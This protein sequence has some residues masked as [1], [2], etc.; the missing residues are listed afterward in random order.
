MSD[1]AGRARVDKRPRVLCVDDEPAVLDS[2]RRQLYAE[3]A[4]VGAE[5][6]PEALA[7]L[8]KDPSFAV[9]V[10]DMRM[11]GMDG[12]TV[13]ARA[14]AMR[15]GTVRVL[16]T[17]HADVEDAIAAVNDG[18]VFRYLVKPC[19]RAVLVDAL[20][21]AV[22]EHRTIK[23]ERE[24]VEHT[25]RGSVSALFEVL[26]LA[27][28]TAF[29]RAA[30]IRAIV[31]EMVEAMRPEQAWRIE[32]AAMLSQIGTVVLAPETVSKL[33]AGLPLS[34]EERSQVDLLAAPLRACWRRSRV[35]TMSAP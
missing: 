9:L 13:L 7:L 3:F 17:G 18:N 28:P 5:S 30:R 25:L 23:A 31:L 33:N 34:P 2:L 6:G 27:N 15:P 35:S 19:P 21:D 11:P 10:T 26:S 16:L 1:A 12:A 4:V 24:L 8:G 14:K 32:I 22:E 20:T 29:A